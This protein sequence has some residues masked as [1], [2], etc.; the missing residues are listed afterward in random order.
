[1]STTHCVDCEAANRI[2]DCLLTITWDEDAVVGAA[3][4]HQIAFSSRG[5]LGTELLASFVVEALPR[6]CDEAISTWVPHA[7]VIHASNLDLATVV[8]QLISKKNRAILVHRRRILLT[9]ALHHGL[10]VEVRV[11][12]TN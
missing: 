3:C 7:L 10:G 11:A 9:P 12:T 6:R 2:S 5:I 1:V 8:T 4:R